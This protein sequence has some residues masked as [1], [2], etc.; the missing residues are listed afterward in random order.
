MNGQNKMKKENEKYSAS[1]WFHPVQY[2]MKGLAEGSYI[3]YLCTVSDHWAKCWNDFKL[4]FEQILPLPTAL[5]LMPE[6]IVW[7]K[8]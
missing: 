3:T 8:K 7:S 5:A 1:M 2:G 4:T 6:S